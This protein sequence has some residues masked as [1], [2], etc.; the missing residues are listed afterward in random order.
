M[1]WDKLNFRE[2]SL[3][4]FLVVIMAYKIDHVDHSSISGHEHQKCYCSYVGLLE[5]S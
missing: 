5:M 4:R 3:L 2:S 1:P